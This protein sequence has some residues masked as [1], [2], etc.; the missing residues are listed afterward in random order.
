MKMILPT[1][2][3]LMIQMSWKTSEMKVIQRIQIAA[4]PPTDKE[5]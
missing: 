3:I 2:K 4:A 5:R 1:R